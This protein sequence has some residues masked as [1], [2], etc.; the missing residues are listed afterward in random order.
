MNA[1]W[2]SFPP[3]QTNTGQTAISARS[4]R[5]KIGDQVVSVFKPNVKPNDAMIGVHWHRTVL[6][7]PTMARNDQRL[8]AAQLTAMKN[9]FQCVG[10]ERFNLI[11]PTLLSTQRWTTRLHLSS[12]LANSSCGNDGCNGKI[13]RSTCGCC[14]MKSTIAGLFRRCE[15][16]AMAMFLNRES[17]ATHSWAKCFPPMVKELSIEDFLIMAFDP[18]TTPATTSLWP[19]MYLVADWPPNQ[20]PF[21]KVAGAANCSSCYRSWW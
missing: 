20:Y 6:G 11:N 21:C 19:L 15:P 13:T 16:T 10:G 4:G 9:R 17:K 18:V 12:A 7:N 8:V 3:L 14:A 1:L 5:F 2:F